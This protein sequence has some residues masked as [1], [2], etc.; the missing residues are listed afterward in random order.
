V[1][2]WRILG[3]VSSG[4][5]LEVVLGGLLW[6]N[7]FRRSWSRER[8]L[9]V[10]HDLNHGLNNKVRLKRVQFSLALDSLFLYRSQHTFSCFLGFIYSGRHCFS[11]CGD[12]VASI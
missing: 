7:I 5:G 6:A 10:N 3:K 2:L 12:L 11:E 8:F 9:V 4:G 1:L